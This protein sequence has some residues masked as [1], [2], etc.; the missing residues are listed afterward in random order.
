LQLTN[1]YKFCKLPENNVLSYDEVKLNFTKLQEE[2]IENR[3]LESKII[4]SDSNL[5]DNIKP[6]KDKQNN[7]H[8]IENDYNKESLKNYFIYRNKRQYSAYEFNDFAEKNKD[9]KELI[10][11][12]KILGDKLK[13]FDK[14]IRKKKSEEDFNKAVEEIK[15]YQIKN[16]EQLNEVDL[17]Y[18]KDDIKIN[19]KKN[20]H[21][22]ME[23]FEKIMDDSIL[24]N[25]NIAYFIKNNCN[26]YKKYFYFLF[27][28]I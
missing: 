16:V 4:I 19:L 10:E 18:N 24:V 3:E 20:P 15:N 12:Q 28:F 26:F 9:S 23:S 17:N 5:D 2:K 13:H 14:L 21:Q 8:N 11:V 1:F 22:K 7:F 27:Y 25:T 6:N